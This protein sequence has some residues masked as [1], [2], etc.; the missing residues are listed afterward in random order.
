MHTWADVAVIVKA[1]SKPGR[2][3]ARAA[4]GLPFLL[5]E[6]DV[7]SFVPPKLDVPRQAEVRSVE[8]VDEH[9][10][11]VEFDGVETA[12]V[13]RELVGMH[14]L[15]RRSEIDGELFEDAPGLWEEWDVVDGQLGKVGVVVGIVDNAAQ[16]LLEVAEADRTFLVP[17]VDDIVVGLDVDAHIVHVELPQGLMDL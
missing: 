11:E 10:A 2:F 4:A 15:I 5:E 17:I 9:K 7:V 12:D 16:S 8:L 6:G 14:C 13:A 1:R 3:A